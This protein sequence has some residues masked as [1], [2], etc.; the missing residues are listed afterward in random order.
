MLMSIISQQIFFKDWISKEVFEM[1]SELE[2][3]IFMVGMIMSRKMATV[4]KPSGN[5]NV[6]E[7][8]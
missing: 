5:Y 6:Y 4:K 3:N 2:E 7:T 8:Q 1:F